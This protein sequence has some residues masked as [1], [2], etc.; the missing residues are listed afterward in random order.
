MLVE[1]RTL[2]FATLVMIV[3]A[4]L[5]SSVAG[6][7]YLQN[8]TNSEQIAE[9]QQSFN[10]MATSYNEAMARYDA[11]LSDFS[12]LQ[13]NYSYPLNT[14]FTLLT[15]LFIDL[16]ENVKGNFSSLLAE[17]K[18]LNQ[19]HFAL[20]SKSQMLLLGGNV[21][22]EEFGELLDGSFEF[23][24][25]LAIRELSKTVSEVTTLTVNICI[26]YGNGTA[27]WHNETEIRTG[28][29]VF[30]LTQE[31]AK[32]DS[33][34]DSL[35]RP[36]H[37]RITSINDKTEYTNYELGFSEGAAWLWYYWDDA[38]QQWIFGP[39]GCDAWM[40]KDGGVYKWVFEYWHWP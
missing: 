27:E 14:N 15:S 33:T 30:Q 6:F 31:V 7:F 11:L 20:Q 28:S 34:Y 24:N 39:V 3:W 35:M 38:K 18:D 36:G 32:T 12:F 25:L 26:E 16:L 40:L 9:N 23:L 13:G 19:T 2:V 37:I 1:K 17:Q 29:S 4:V 10:T 21:T 5:A 8:T 22:R